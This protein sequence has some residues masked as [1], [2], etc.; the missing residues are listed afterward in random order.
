MQLTGGV[1]YKTA[2]FIKKTFLNISFV[3]V[4]TKIPRLLTDMLKCRAQ[5]HPYKN[6]ARQKLSGRRLP[7]Q[8][9]T[10]VPYAPSRKLVRIAAKFGEPITREV[11]EST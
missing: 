9:T 8:A 10:Y 1:L 6:T 5:K 2:M 7:Q 11:R 4:L 3:Y